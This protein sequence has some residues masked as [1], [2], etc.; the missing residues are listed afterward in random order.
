[1]TPTRADLDAPGSMTLGTHRPS[2]RSHRRLADSEHP[3]I[4]TTELD[5]FE[6]DGGG[7]A[8]DSLMSVLDHLAS[9]HSAGCD[10]TARRTR[11]R[12][13]GHGF[14]L[15]SAEWL[16]APVESAAV[17]ICSPDLGLL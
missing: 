3:P 7:L 4:W 5:G 16:S 12:L 6:V 10:P 13:S 9:S 2:R 11:F 17:A 14:A 8:S 15:R 1:M